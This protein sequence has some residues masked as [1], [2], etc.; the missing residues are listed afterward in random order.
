VHMSRPAKPLFANVVLLAAI[1]LASCAASPPEALDAS[2][3]LIHKR[4]LQRHV[5]WLAHDERAGRMTGEAG[6]D[7]AAEYVAAQLAAM[8]VEPAGAD[9][10]YQPVPLRTFKAK[11]EASRFVIHDAAGDE[12]LV[13]RDAFSVRPD[14]V[15]PARQV[16]AEVVYAGYGIHAPDLGY[17]DYE[18][19]D[20]RGKIV[21]L[22]GGAPD[23]FV[24]ATRAFYASSEARRTELV[25]RGAIGTIS[26]RSR[27]DEEARSWEASKARIDQ[28]A[29]MTWV[30]AAGEAAGHFPQI[31]GAA[32]ISP[33][34]AAALFAHAPLTY[35]ASLDAM[36]AGT[37]ASASLG[38]EVTIA[39][40]SL[41]SELTSPNVVGLVRG[42]DPVLADE[43]VVY[44][45]HLDHLGT[46]EEAGE[47]RIFNGVYDN[48]MG[49][50]LMLETARA[51]AALP[52][53]RSV[54][55]VAVTAEEK[56][57][58]GSDYFVNHPTVPRAAIVANINLDM[59]L[60]LYPV[61]D[62]VAFGSENST[63]QGVAERG[64]AAEGFVLS[65][66]PFP[67]EN[68][69]VRSDQFSFVRKGIP[70]IFLVTGFASL[71]DRVD[72][73]A[74]YRD[75][76][77]NH[78]HA[79]SDDLGRPIDWAS[80]VRFAR[81]HARMGYDIAT[82]TERPTWLEGNVFGT[83]FATP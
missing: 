39:G 61:A 25:A 12:A 54:L 50:A 3:G 28:R 36:E 68:L 60:F 71:D 6:Y 49:V 21:A 34:A 59:P 26:L 81:A 70:A 32:L 69:F 29:S 82:N 74:A 16:R 42:T 80:A 41:H 52:P 17:S 40:E 33:Q 43:Y 20:V 75:H 58:L 57:L 4:A 2:L 46:R 73:E 23:G 78:Y 38:V 65:P 53:R 44:T 19:I 56:G 10:W 76:V 7:R 45:A 62:L 24:G 37:V 18:G 63:L 22:Y 35:E 66:D 30:S 72:G 64:A 11:G 15:S 48:A 5:A 79:A 31:Q 27:K 14:P 9:G 1:M 8:G 47:Q 67:E 55:F 77:R 83:R 13:Y 51:F